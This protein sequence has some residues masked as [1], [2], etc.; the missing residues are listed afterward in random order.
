MSSAGLPG[1]APQLAILPA[2][3]PD[4][5]E[6]ARA[7]FIE[8]Q[9][10]L[11]VDLCFQGFAQELAGLP[12]AYAPPRGG[13]WFAKLDGEIAGVVALRPM[14]EAGVC[15][16][17]RL[18]VRPAFRGLGLGRRLAETA[19]AAARA[20]GYGRMLL[21]TLPQMTDARRLYDALGFRETTPYYHNP[22]TGVV[23]MELDLAPRAARSG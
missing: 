10:W 17:K 7:L 9:A 21:D 5:M 15:E 11:D 18:W 16:L 6:R 23:Y 12:G 22:V 13:L 14:A 2:A 1:K 4:D 8:Y 3:G 20:A 19:L